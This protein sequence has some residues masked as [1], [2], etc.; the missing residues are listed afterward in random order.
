MGK[1]EKQMKEQTAQA[2]IPGRNG[3]RPKRSSEGREDGRAFLTHGEGTS[4]EAM[5]IDHKDGEI[6]RR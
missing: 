6:T 5:T 3:Q 1:G 2:R 4:R